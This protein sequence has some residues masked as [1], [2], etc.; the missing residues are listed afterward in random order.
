M[1]FKGGRSVG[2][3]VSNAEEIF[4]F[5]TYK[6]RKNQILS[7]DML[8]FPHEPLSRFASDPKQKP[9]QAKEVFIMTQ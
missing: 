5:E 8:T 1:V 6:T 9:N 4:I 3:V 2:E 7:A